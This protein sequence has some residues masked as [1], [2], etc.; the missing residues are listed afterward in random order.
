MSFNEIAD[1]IRAIAVLI[2][3][4][5]FAKVVFR[6]PTW[7]GE[8]LKGLGPIKRL[9][10]WDIEAELDAKPPT[11]LKGVTGKDTEMLPPVSGDLVEKHKEIENNEIET[12]VEKVD[13]DVSQ[14][15]AL[16]EQ[17]K[18]A[19]GMRII[20]ECATREEDKK[21]SFALVAFSQYTA[22]IHGVT[23]A[24][25]DLQKTANQYPKNLTVQQ[26]LAE[27]LAHI[28]QYNVAVENLKE[29]QKLTDKESDKVALSLV[30]VS[31]YQ[32]MAEYNNALTL[33]KSLA[34]QVE[35]FRSKAKIYEAL[36]TTYEKQTPPDYFKAF[37][38]Y[39][40]ALY[41]S[42]SDTDLRFKVAY[43]Y[44]N[45]QA[46]GLAFYHYRELLKI[47]GNH[48]MA[49][50]NAGVA[51]QQLSLPITSV[52][53]YRRSEEHGETLAMS[54]LAY[55]L[56]NEGFVVEAEDILEKARILENVDDGV[57]L[58]IGSV[59]SARQNEETQIE[60]IS[61]N[62]E[63][64]R[65]WRLKFSES[66]VSSHMKYGS[67]TGSY[68]GTPAQ[69][70]LDVDES[71]NVSGEFL[72]GSFSGKLSGRMEGTALRFSWNTIRSEETLYSPARNG[73]GVLI[74]NGTSASGYSVEKQTSLD[75]VPMKNWIDWELVKER[76]VQ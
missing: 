43:T 59:V 3:V 57:Q 13:D 15:L 20:R 56:L 49:L 11:T 1:L 22:F 62:V 42:P 65:K 30:L 18:Y 46:N 36:A 5:V 33:L 61:Q 25:A 28:G 14:A 69:L 16:L 50:N 64:V 41:H 63:R 71:G 40:Q 44:S 9:K 34:T 23:E 6:P 12:N 48:S 66:L 17:G 38:M 73:Y 51:A 70:Q 10:L 55:K 45:Q 47:K 58:A 76:V 39:E 19:E 27:A 31:I 54:N 32:R 37:A 4:L 2:G 74:F 7:L 67:L 21:V 52:R 72:L 68:T 35:D 60:E 75:A 29:A 24:L 26:S 53:Y 8:A